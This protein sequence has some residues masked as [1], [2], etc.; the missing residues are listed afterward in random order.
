MNP[1]L[2]AMSSYFDFLRHDRGRPANS[3]RRLRR[4]LRQ[5]PL[6]VEALEDR[7]LPSVALSISD[8]SATEGSSSLQFIDNL[9]TSG[10]GG[11][12]LPRAPAFGPDGNLYVVSTNTNSILRY[13]GV[14]GQFKDVFITTG[15]GGLNSP[16]DLAFSPDYSFRSMKMAFDRV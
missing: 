16:A 11:L 6:C 4:R 5:P 3:R 7:F 2:S 1:L 9:V 8:A 10:S 15:S 12:S 13:D 14:T